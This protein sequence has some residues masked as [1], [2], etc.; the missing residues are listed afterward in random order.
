LQAQLQAQA[1]AI[2]RDEE[3]ALTQTLAEQ[4]ASQQAAAKHV[5]RLREES[6]ELR[7]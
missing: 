5:Q 3:A 4:L 1:A 6:A 7:E 2:V